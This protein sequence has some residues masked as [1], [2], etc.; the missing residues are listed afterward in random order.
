MLDQILYPFHSQVIANYLQPEPFWVRGSWDTAACDAQCSGN[1]T[2]AAITQ[3]ADV[4]CSR[5]FWLLCSGRDS[6]VTTAPTVQQM[7]RKQAIMS[8][9]CDFM[10]SSCPVRPKVQDPGRAPQ[11]LAGNALQR[12]SVSPSWMF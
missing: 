3:V 11:S 10:E 1:A 9:S 2:N 5:G 12:M 6:T 7:L 8:N 4:T